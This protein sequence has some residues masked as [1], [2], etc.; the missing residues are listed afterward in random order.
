[1]TLVEVAVFRAEIR[2]RNF[3]IVKHIATHWT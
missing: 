3:P 1:M 2:T